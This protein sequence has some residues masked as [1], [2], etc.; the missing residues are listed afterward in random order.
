M[1]NI[2]AS[3][4]DEKQGTLKQEKAERTVIISLCLC[5]YHKLNVA[6]HHFTLSDAQVVLCGQWNLALVFTDSALGSF[7]I[8]RFLGNATGFCQGFRPHPSLDDA[9]NSI[10]SPA[11]FS[12]LPTLASSF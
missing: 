8:R 11:L 1:G 12:E 6:L 4:L 3:I 5:E 7:S 2:V 9:S 10:S